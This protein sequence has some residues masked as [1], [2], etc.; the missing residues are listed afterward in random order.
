MAASRFAHIPAKDVRFWAWL[1]TSVTWSLA[2]PPMAP[3]FVGFL[4]WLNGLIGGTG[5]APVFEPVHILFVSITGS[6]VSIW[7]I[8]RLLKP[9]GL[10]SVIDGWGRLWIGACIVWIILAMGGPPVLWL[11]VFTEWIGAVAQLRAAY[12]AKAA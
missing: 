8:A 7:C 5:T 12:F 1:D 11:F 2:L 3:K 4:Y 6:L 9:E 10:L